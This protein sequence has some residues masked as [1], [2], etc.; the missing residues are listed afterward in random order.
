MRLDR[1]IVVPAAAGLVLWAKGI[2]FAG[3]CVVGAVA[4]VRVVPEIINRVERTGE[5]TESRKPHAP[6]TAVAMPSGPM[7]RPSPPESRVSDAVMPAAAA[8]SSTAPVREG[9]PSVHERATAPTTTVPEPPLERD[10]LERE[11]AMLEEARAMLDR[12]PIGA[13]S[14]LERHAA[15]FPIGQ[16]GMERELLAVQA[17]RRLGRQAEA[18]ARGDALLRQASGS[19]YEPRVRAM[20]EDLGSP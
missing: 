10:P 1:V 19:I 18:R 7:V 6:P 14:V 11:A 2:A 17:L 9:A 20:L 15:T 12:Y 8:P 4:A 13:L 5:L 16:L 3:L